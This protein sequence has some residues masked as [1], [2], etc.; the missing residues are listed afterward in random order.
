MQF[1]KRALALTVAAI[2]LAGSA[3]VSAQC[4]CTNDAHN[5]V[6]GTGCGAAPVPTFNATP[7]V[8][9]QIMTFYVQCNLPNAPLLLASSHSVASPFFVPG[10]C[11]IYLDLATLMFNG[12]F[13]TD[14]LGNWTFDWLSPNDPSLCGLL[15]NLQVG[16]AAPGGPN[17]AAQFTNALASTMGCAPPGN[18][19]EFPDDAFCS[20]TPGGFQGG[21]VPGQ[22][23]ANNFLTV[24]AGGL[25]VGQY[26]PGNG[27]S[28]PNGLRWDATTTGRANLKTFIAGGGPS[29]VIAS[30]Q[31]NPTTG[32]GGGSLANH[33]AALTLNIGFNNAGLLGSNMT[34]WANLVYINPGDSLSGRSITQILAAANDALAGLGL[35]AGYT[36]GSFVTLLDHLNSSW[37]NCLISGWASTHLFHP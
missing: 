13:T 24:F 28:V 21:G 12:P 5:V 20:Y 7:P 14:A 22:I 10:G 34:G 3:G 37:D 32:F 9:G 6:I 17:P 19:N 11:A 1:P 30:D 25:E 2:V 18:G 31:L 29:G 26:N 15:C 36:F 4:I 16:I 35:P 23:Y 33:A 8:V 27:N